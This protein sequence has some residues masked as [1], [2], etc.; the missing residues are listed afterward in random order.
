MKE[1]K[2]SA[3]LKKG[4]GAWGKKSKKEL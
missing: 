1:L 2:T 3:N 4:L